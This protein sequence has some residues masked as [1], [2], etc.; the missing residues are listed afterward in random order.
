MVVLF[1]REQIVLNIGWWISMTQ[2]LI[3]I[4]DEIFDINTKPIKEFIEK[5]YQVEIIKIK[6]LIGE[7]FSKWN[8]GKL[9]KEEQ[10]YVD[11]YTENYSHLDLDDYLEQFLHEQYLETDENNIEHKIML[12]LIFQELKKEVVE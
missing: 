9:T 10:D 3:E 1:V 2:L 7:H 8:F 4:Y 5:N 12:K 11:K 6:E